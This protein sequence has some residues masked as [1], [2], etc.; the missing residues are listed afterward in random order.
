MVSSASSTT[1]EV[2]V[3]L[4]PP[5]AADLTAAEAEDVVDD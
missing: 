5:L 1:D 4:T 3:D 2:V